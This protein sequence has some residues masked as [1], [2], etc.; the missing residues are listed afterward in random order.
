MSEWM[1]L[2]GLPFVTAF[3]GWITNWS[4]VKMIFW[5]ERFIGVGPLG[6]Q[7]IVYRYNVKFAEGASDL[8]KGSLYSARDIVDRIEAEELEELYEGAF[9]AQALPV[10]RRC[11]EV[12]RPGVWDQLPENVRTMIVEQVRREG[13]ETLA[14]LFE[15]FQEDSDEL[16]DL[17][18]MAVKALTQDGGRTMAKLVQKFG[19][20]ELGFIELYGAVFGF[21]MG[22]VEAAMWSVFGVWWLL[23][24]AGACVGAITNWLALQMIFRPMEPTRYLGVVTYQGL[25]P[26]RQSEIAR[27]YAHI[28]ATEIVTARNLIGLLTEGEGGE[29]LARLVAHVL[30]ERIDSRVE[31]LRPMLSGSGVELDEATLVRLKQEIL[32]QV[33]QAIPE[34]TPQLETYLDEKLDVANI[35]RERMSQLSKPEF[36]RILRGVFEEDEVILIVLGALLGGLI[37]AA[38]G[39]FI[40][41]G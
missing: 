27:D 20:K 9:Q 17:K 38:Q 1:L 37:G 33:V 15:R 11:A 12:L 18:R 3:V 31:M 7:G 23:P 2:L 39:A 21:G 32:G 41:L 19:A 6:W 10:V 26:K 24:V 40:G 14:E 16:L 30:D 28:S 25:F 4:V 22:V 34:V 13:R 8:V 5:P 36:E 29:R 35:I